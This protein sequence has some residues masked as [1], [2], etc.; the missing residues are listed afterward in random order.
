MKGKEIPKNI[1]QVPAIDLLVLMPNEKLPT[2][3]CC[4]AD[5]HNCSVL[6][7]GIVAFCDAS[8]F[9]LDLDYHL[10]SGVFV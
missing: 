5:R 8:V 9:C 6:L 7:K 4:T 3:D 1:S 2:C 10:F